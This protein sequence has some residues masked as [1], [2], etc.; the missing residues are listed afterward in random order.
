MFYAHFD[1]GGGH[2][3]CR[4]FTSS[5]IIICHTALPSRPLNMAAIIKNRNFFNCLLLLYYKSKWAQILMYLHGIEQYSISSIF[6]SDFFFSQLMLIVHI[7][8]KNKNYIKIFGIAVKISL[9]GKK[10]IEKSAEIQENDYRLQGASSC[11]G[12]DQLKQHLV[13]LNYLILL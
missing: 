4:Y 6:F 1:M 2:Y 7:M 8:R 3:I 12:K 13:S 10:I 5:G 9:N 11:F